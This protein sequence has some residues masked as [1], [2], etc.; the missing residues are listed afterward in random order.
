MGAP[1]FLQQLRGFVLLA[2]AL[3]GGAVPLSAQPSTTAVQ[4][5]PVSPAPATTAPP[6]ATT[7]P[8]ATARPPKF[9][10][11]WFASLNAIG[12]ARL[13]P[14]GKWIA[15]SAPM[16]GVDRLVVSDPVTKQA[17]FTFMFDKE[18]ELNWFR[19]AGSGKVLF[20]MGSTAKYLGD[21][22]RLTRMYVSDI[23]TTKTTYVGP[24]A[25]GFVGDDLLHIDP[26]G[27]F[28]LVA[29][30]RSIFD[31]PS[32]WRFPLDGTAKKAGRE[33]QK[34]IEGAW[35]WYCDT[36]GNLRMAIVNQDSQI[37]VLYRT[38]PDSSFKTIVTMTRK[39]W[40]EKQWDVTR[41]FEGSDDGFAV[42]K[43]LNNRS[44][45]V[46]F[47][48]ATR[49][50]GETIY[51]SPDGEVTD[52]D[53]GDDHQLTAVYYTDDQD[54][55]IWYDPKMKKLQAQLSRALPGS[56]LWISSRSK[57]DTRMLVWQSTASD[58][59]AVY[60]F[61]AKARSLDLLTSMRPAL[62]PAQLAAPTPIDYK[63]RDG[64]SIRA[65]LTLPKGRVAKGLPLVILPHGGPYGVRDKLQYDDEVQF[66]ANRGYA[67]LQPNYRGSDGYG[68]GFAGLGDGQIGRTMQDDLDDGM[69]ALVKLGTVDATR[70]CIVGTSYGGYA[71]AWGIIRNPERYRCAAS[72]AG[73]M[74]WKRQLKY[75]NQDSDGK[76]RRSWSTRVM[77]EDAKFDLD[78]VSP[79]AQA[80]RITRPLL[81]VHGDKDSRV[82]YVQF[83]EMSAALT[84]AKIP[85]EAIVM[86]GEGHGFSKPE[87]E[88]KWYTALDGFLGKHNPAD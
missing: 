49:V 82:P 29:V 44:V 9:P 59:G 78:T 64:V 74:N 42:Q 35:D 72:F 31:Y 4:E 68:E 40:Q 23:E 39:N 71:A 3:A 47:N 28:A 32:V 66:L 80:A 43:D 15:F 10:A 50:T 79:T 5:A 38:T 17:K 51:T 18:H 87:N 22:V 53:T 48:Y 54:K 56:G 34:Q 67:V 60:L 84:A 26:A 8:A 46:K 24:S 76:E 1:T 20:S 37:K 7:A 86:P 25:V 13:S 75:Q 88:E 55:V 11:S 62:N 85:F 58:P 33:I 73:V 41:I 6:P 27:Q 63:A 69:D 19:W 70:V 57:D 45:L 81:L 52:F 36:A 65:Y 2:A 21:D 77:G 12:N 16:N 61:D 30:Q 14:D 83:T